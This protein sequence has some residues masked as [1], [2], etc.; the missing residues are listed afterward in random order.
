MVSRTTRENWLEYTGWLFVILCFL[1]AFLVPTWWARPLAYMFGGATL[2]V[3]LAQK[4]LI[5]TRNA[6]HGEMP[7]ST[8]TRILGTIGFWVAIGLAV[9]LLYQILTRTGG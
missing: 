7:R 8:L 1:L 9:L 4:F 2:G 5:E 6:G 3:C